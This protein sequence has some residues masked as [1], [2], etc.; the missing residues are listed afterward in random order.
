MERVLVTGANRGL[1]LEFVRQYADAGARV[2]AACREP[3]GAG[4]LRE[5]CSGHSG[6]D[7][8]ELDVTDADAIDAAVADVAAEDGGRLDILINN[9]GVSPRGERFENLE[10]ETML[11]VYAVNT[12]APAIVAQRF[13]PLLARSER[14]RIANISSTLGSLAKKDYGRLYSY[15][16]SKAALNMITRA[17]ACDLADDGIVVA[18]LHPGWVQTDLGGPKADLTPA[19]SVAGLIE[20][21][22]G[23]T[24]AQSGRFLAWDG[25]EPPW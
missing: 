20:V 3:A 7:I 25:S 23:L 21:I 24:P 9:A 2:F 5:I 1:G 19:E 14:P 4:A 18:A 12:V 15:A 8:L 13:R 16:S 6:V 17:A 10:S 11:D 22:A